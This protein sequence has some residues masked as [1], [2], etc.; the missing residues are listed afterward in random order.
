MKGIVIK[1]TGSWYSVLNEIEEVWECRILGKFRIQEI[2]STNPIAVGDRVEFEVEDAE[3][4]Q[5]IIIKL[6]DRDN[7]I[8]RKSVNLSK[9]T[10]IIAA[11]I[12]QAFLVV[13]FAKPR[14]SFGFIDRFLV[15]SE[16]YHIPTVLIFNKID[17]YEADDLEYLEEVKDM[18]ESIGYPVLLVSALTAEGVEELKNQCKNKTS[19][20]SGHSGVG[21]S[22]LV[23]QIIPGIQLKTTA[24][25]DASSKG[26]HTTT[27]AEMHRIPSGGFII[28]SP[29]IRELGIVELEKEEISHYFP[30]MR[31]LLNDCRFNNCTHTNEPGCAIKKAVDENRISLIR[32][33]SYLSILANED[34]RN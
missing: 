18:Y 4:K 5:G 23:N 17:I 28:D 31:D 25:S 20:F 14:T 33:E 7:Y 6:F 9:Q 24:I 15:T 21:K 30:E 19:L 8:I 29:G 26:M 10:Q 12:D 11:N 22:T 32:Y 16:A 2:K 13:T 27:F 34:N 3:R 1:S